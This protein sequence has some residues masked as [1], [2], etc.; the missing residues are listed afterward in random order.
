MKPNRFRRPFPKVFLALP[1]LLASCSTQPSSTGLSVP[2]EQS[3]SL[4]AKSEPAATSEPAQES[5]NV[6]VSESSVTPPPQA[7]SSAPSPSSSVPAA[8]SSSSSSLPSYPTL[9][10]GP[11]ASRS[12]LLPR[13]RTWYQLLTYSFADGNGDG[14]GDFLGIIQHLDYLE[15]LGIGG[16]WLSPFHPSVDYHGYTVKD[17]YAVDSALTPTVGGVAYTLEKL[18]EECHKRDIKVLMDAVFNHT[19]TSHPWRRQHPEWYANNNFFGDHSPELDY[20]VP[21][22][23]TEMKNVGKYWVNKGIDGFRLDAAQWIFNEGMTPGDD[24]IDSV[25]MGKTVAWWREFAEAVR[26]VNPNVYMVGEVLTSKPSL[27][28]DFLGSGA[29]SAFDFTRLDVLGNAIKST[30]ASD[31]AGHVAYHQSQIRAKSDKSI[32]V[33]STL[34]A[35]SAMPGN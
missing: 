25:N 10:F 20:S 28:M 11:F 31:W 17:Y 29:G 9:D 19:G 22:V 6:S 18:I 8:S 32:S 23:R 26:T 3:E 27:A 1:L 34:T 21:A 30:N 24:R 15:N 33:A 13:H 4:P 12:S 35:A 16:I 7:S 2:V 14:M 5:V